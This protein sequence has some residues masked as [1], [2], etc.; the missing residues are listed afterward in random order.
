MI[1]I[2]GITPRHK[3]IGPAEE[4]TCTHCHNTR[5][6]LLKKESQWFSL[7]FIPLIPFGTKHLLQCPICGMAE[8]LT[9]DE[10]QEMQAKATLNKEA[11]S[12]RMK[13]DEYQKKYTDL[14]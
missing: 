13:P 11:L 3:V 10:F 5:F 12:G 8:Q 9:Q 6:W 4:R 2:F 7:F 14:K 1:F